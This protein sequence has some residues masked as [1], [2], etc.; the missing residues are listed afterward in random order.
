MIVPYMEAYRLAQSI[1][2]LLDFVKRN[3]C[4]VELSLHRKS[5]YGMK[6]YVVYVCFAH[7]TQVDYDQ[8]MTSLNG[9]VV[10]VMLIMRELLTKNPTILIN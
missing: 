3:F 9:F 2:K 1:W 5:L 7:F 8:Q 6:L 4:F 10:C